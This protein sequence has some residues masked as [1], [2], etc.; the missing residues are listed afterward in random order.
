MIRRVTTAL[1][2]LACVS[3]AGSVSAATVVTVDPAKIT[4]GYMNVFFRPA[5]GGAFIFGSPWG[6]GDLVGSYSGSN[7]TLSPNTIGD[8]DP[9]WYIG[10]GGPGAAGNK[11]ME[12][13]AYAEENGP[14]A[15]VTLVF[16]GQVFSNT[17][18]TAHTVL[19]FIKD[20]APDFSSN[21]STY[22]PLPTSGYFSITQ[23][24][25]NDVARHVQYGFQVTGPNVWVTD[26]AP[27]GKAVI[28]PYYPTPNRATT[29]G[30]IKT[31]YA[32]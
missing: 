15:G 25:V 22:I 14:L 30:R 24:I 13:N 5:D 27:F 8:P 32:K 6:F 1:A 26:T 20:F 7:L 19:A 10:G 28:G 11:I 18:T 12:A 9:F 31:L 29:W 23:P 21:V 3:L 17:F 4:N 2:F 16:G